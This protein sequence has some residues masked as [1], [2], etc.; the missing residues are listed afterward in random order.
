MP[1]LA[2]PASTRIDCCASRSMLS[3]D[4]FSGSVEKMRSISTGVNA[5]LLQADAS[6]AVDR[7]SFELMFLSRHQAT[8][9][10]QKMRGAGP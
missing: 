9:L 4:L 1:F 10:R 6:A 7:D 8:F 5:L 3:P 2:S